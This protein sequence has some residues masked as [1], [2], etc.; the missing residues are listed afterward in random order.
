M[1]FR[2]L[3][4]K[5]PQRDRSRYM[6]Y[7]SRS[8]PLFPGLLP[9]F[10]R[11]VQRK[12]RPSSRQEEASPSVEPSMR[13]SSGVSQLISSIPAPMVK[14]L[15]QQFTGCRQDGMRTTKTPLTQAQTAMQGGP[16]TSSRIGFTAS[17]LP[18]RISAIH[19]APPQNQPRQ[20]ADQQSKH[21]ATPDG[22]T[23]PF[24]SAT[25]RVTA[26]LTPMCKP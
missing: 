19:P 17:G 7:L 23:P 2:V 21:H 8:D 15:L 1:L 12:H 18:N 13:A 11:T 22:R 10:L 20:P 4:T 24:P 14:N 25:R 5:F 3:R 9:R 6:R 16:G 26:R